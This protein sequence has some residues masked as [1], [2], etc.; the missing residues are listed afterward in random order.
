LT[1]LFTRLNKFITSGHTFR[2]IPLIFV[3]LRKIFIRQPHQ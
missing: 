2:S 3:F 1:S